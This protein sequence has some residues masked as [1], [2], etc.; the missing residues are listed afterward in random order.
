[1]PGANEEARCWQVLAES[2]RPCVHRALL[3]HD[4]SGKP[5]GHCLKLYTGVDQFKA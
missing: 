1:M 4:L 2:D 5:A 3:K